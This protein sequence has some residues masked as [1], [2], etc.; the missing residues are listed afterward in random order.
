[1]VWLLLGVSSISWF[2]SSLAG[3]GS[4]LILIP[5]ASL[6]L[7]AAAVPPI[8]T[9]GMLCGNS[10]RIWLYRDNIDA[11]V[12]R[13]YVPGAIVGA[14]LGAFAFSRMQITWLS[15]LLGLF[16]IASIF[17]Y[18]LSQ[19]VSAFRVRAWYFL[20]AGFIYAFL[21]GLIGSTGPLLNPFYLNYGLN[22]DELIGTKSL[23]VSVVHAVKI[24]AYIAFGVF[25]KEYFLYGVLIGVGALPGNWLGRRVLDSM[26]EQRFRQVVMAFVAISGALLL[27][28][29]R[30]VLGLS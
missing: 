19:Q 6:F 27:W 12:T 14:V 5:V 8:I 10:Q 17:T 16:L 21:S 7:G 20:P 11:T 15:L 13:W 24:L 4:P 2:I 26:G 30:Q 29:Q 22:K 1:M 18:N 3:G 25:T 23:G 28:D 9:L